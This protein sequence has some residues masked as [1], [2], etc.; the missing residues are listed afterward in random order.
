MRAR[1][2]AIAASLTQLKGLSTEIEANAHAFRANL[3]RVTRSEALASMR[4]LLS[5]IR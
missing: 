2:T 1:S 5:S 4:T 3:E